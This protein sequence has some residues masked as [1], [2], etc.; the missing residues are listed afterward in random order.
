MGFLYVKTKKVCR[1]FANF[2]SE[3]EH[4]T[5]G[6]YIS[7]LIRASDVKKLNRSCSYRRNDARV[8]RH[9][10]AFAIAVVVTSRFSSF[11]YTTSVHAVHAGTEKMCVIL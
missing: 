7:A 11:E 2:S 5:H 3:Q 8:F 4:F 6:I 10:I 9:S 1:C